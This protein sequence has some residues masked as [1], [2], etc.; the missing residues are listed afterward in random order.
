[1]ADRDFNI[2]IVGAPSLDEVKG[3]V[4][5]PTDPT[6]KKPKTSWWYNNVGVAIT[7]NDREDRDEKNF[8]KEEE[9]E[10]YWN[11]LT[12]S[13]RFSL[14]RDKTIDEG[15]PSDMTIETWQGLEEYQ[16]AYYRARKLAAPFNIIDD[17]G[18]GVT[19]GAKDTVINA[20]SL[21]LALRDV[22]QGNDEATTQFFD[23]I[24]RLDPLQP[25]NSSQEI[26]SLFT[27]FGAP[28]VAVVGGRHEPSNS[29]WTKLSNPT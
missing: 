27:R 7:Q 9:Y 15:R 21:P 3:P 25:Q 18:A 24:N 4:D 29:F 1:M 14:T 12:D 13:E 8:I 20:F 28:S 26:I 6:V 22:I 16:R 17:L 5:S 11:S 2:E 10:K 23:V 19:I